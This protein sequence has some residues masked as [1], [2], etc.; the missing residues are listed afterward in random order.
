MMKYD[1]NNLINEFLY[2]VYFDA[3]TLDVEGLIQGIIY[4]SHSLF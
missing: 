4:S 2:N 3:G 1:K